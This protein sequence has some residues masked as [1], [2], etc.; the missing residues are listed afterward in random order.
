MKKWQ[1]NSSLYNSMTDNAYVCVLSTESYVPGVLALAY[2][3]CAV[4]TK[5]PF[6]VLVPE[7]QHAQF[8]HILSAYSIRVLSAPPI[9][10]DAD[11]LD[12][13][14]V[15]QRVSYWRDTFFKLQIAKLKQFTKI[16]LLDA[17]MIVLR[18]IDHVFAFPHM[19]AVAAGQIKHPHW[20]QLNSGFMVIEPTDSFEYLVQSCLPHAIQ[21][22]CALGNS[23]GDQDIFNYCYKDWPKRTELHLPEVYNTMTDCINLVA[24]RDGLSKIYIAHFIGKTKPWHYTKEFLFK[25][26]KEGMRYMQLSEF[27]LTMKYIAF[28][29]KSRF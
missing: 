3:L 14:V 18:N 20:V 15:D 17:D 6:F 1:Y 11:I 19:S 8:S 5:F 7:H 10:I 9:E 2:S 4:K 12:Q 13:S 23:F 28:L 24:N 16:V 25:R 29:R 26:F 21:E 27:I 22:L